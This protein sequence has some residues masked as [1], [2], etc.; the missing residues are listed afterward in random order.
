M[1]TQKIVTA[2]SI[3]A[4]IVLFLFVYPS[5]D[6]RI[7]AGPSS[8][9]QD[10]SALKTMVPISVSSDAVIAHYFGKDVVEK[11]MKQ[12]GCVGV[13]MYYSKKTN[14]KS[15]FKFVGVDKNGKD[16]APIVIAGPGTFCPPICGG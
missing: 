9:K 8:S 6:N 11:I 1:S 14:G 15:G 5:I 16:M 12:T 10:I 2:A 7:N 13:R 3:V 4:L